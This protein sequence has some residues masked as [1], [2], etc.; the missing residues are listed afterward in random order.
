MTGDMAI[1]EHTLEVAIEAPP[2]RV[3][4]ALTDQTTSWWHPG[5]FSREGALAFRIEPQLGGRVFEDWGDG[6][7]LTWYT[8]TGL[9]REELLQL[10]GDLDVRHGPARIQTTFRLEPRDGRT[11][12]RLEEAVFGRVTEKTRESLAA[13]WRI[14]VEGCLKVYVESGAPPAEWPSM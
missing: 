11:L 9:V 14:L 1:I 6:Q 4:K 13:G 10:C 3:W 5:F 12:L 8:V 7:G 2:A